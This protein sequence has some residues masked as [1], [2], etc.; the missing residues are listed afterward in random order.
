[1][2]P[3]ASKHSALRLISA[4]FRVWRARFAS[5]RH[6][7]ALLTTVL[8][9]RHKAHEKAAALAK[10]RVFVAR[11]REESEEAL[12]ARADE[13]AVRRANRALL[14]QVQTATAAFLDPQSCFFICLDIV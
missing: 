13:M 2:L 8:V 10:W 3:L 1:M 14:T 5:R 6:Q 11:V 7:K 12:R 4:R 9:H